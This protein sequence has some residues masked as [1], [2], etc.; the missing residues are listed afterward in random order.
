MI[1]NNLPKS[2][3]LN[4]SIETKHIKD[5]LD[6]SVIK[7]DNNFSVLGDGTLSINI[8][9]LSKIPDNIDDKFIYLIS[10]SNVI[11]SLKEN[12]REKINKLVINKDGTQFL[13]N[14]G[15]YKTLYEFIKIYYNFDEFTNSNLITV[16]N[17]MKYPSILYAEIIDNNDFPFPNG[18]ISLMKISENSANI[19]FIGLNQHIYT[20]IINNEQMSDWLDMTNAETAKKLEYPIYINKAYF[21]GS[22]SITSSDMNLATGNDTTIE[23]NSLPINTWIRFAIS[24]NR[25]AIGSFLLNFMSD[26]ISF[27]LNFE[28]AI[29]SKVN[30]FQK[31]YDY[32]SSLIKNQI[33]VIYSNE[34]AFVELKINSIITNGLLKIYSYT[35]DFSLLKTLSIDNTI[36]DMNV[37]LIDL[38][39][40]ELCL[41]NKTIN[42]N[43]ANNFYWNI[44]E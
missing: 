40:N 24:N 7:L 33:R 35:N 42:N 11:N 15:T 26:E 32:D 39:S 10:D 9:L 30:F 37:A 4:N 31:I 18:N 1:I 17:E 28:I 16:F 41:N 23:L 6:A 3:I 19:I 14:D 36:N 25:L 5:K 27:N 43:F 2:I 8:K 29:N 44:E 21:D 20:S 34:Q 22:T 38:R 12:E 13:S